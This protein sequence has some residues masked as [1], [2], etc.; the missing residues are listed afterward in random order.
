M[1]IA[2]WTLLP[3]GPSGCS[4]LVCLAIRYLDSVGVQ[5]VDL[6]QEVYLVLVQEGS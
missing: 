2:W 6:V 4:Q 5:V 3:G 1:M